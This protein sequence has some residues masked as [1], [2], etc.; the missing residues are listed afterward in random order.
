MLKHWS[1]SVAKALVFGSRDL[2]LSE[3]EV[4]EAIMEFLEMLTPCLTFSIP[5]HVQTPL[6][7]SRE[8]EQVW[9]L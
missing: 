3:L 2:G 9:K 5:L 7:A 6:V 8:K 1:R 4:Y